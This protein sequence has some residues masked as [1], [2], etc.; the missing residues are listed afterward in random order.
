V[1]AD[2]RRLAHD[3]ARDL[4]DFPGGGSKFTI[5]RD[6]ATRLYWAL[7]NKQKDPPARRNALYLS[8]SLDLRLWRVAERLLFHPDGAFHAF[9]YVDWDFDGDDI[10]YASRTAWDDGLGGARNYHDAN[11]ITF[12]RLASFRGLASRTWE[13]DGGPV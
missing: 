4:I 12:H 2:G 5:R 6:P 13:Q 11:F 8:R 9:Q 7:V 3:P 10:V 1:S